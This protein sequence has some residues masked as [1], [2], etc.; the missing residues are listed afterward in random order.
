MAVIIVDS[1]VVTALVENP[2]FFTWSEF[3]LELT[4]ILANHALQRVIVAI[5]EVIC[6][7]RNS[8]R[9]LDVIR[10]ECKSIRTETFENLSVETSILL[11]RIGPVLVLEFEVV[12]EEV[13]AFNELSSV[14]LCDVTSLITDEMG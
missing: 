4:I 6:A 8:L 13:V 1:W 10:D 14:P 12:I 3:S 2:L 7:F 11:C 9:S 5:S